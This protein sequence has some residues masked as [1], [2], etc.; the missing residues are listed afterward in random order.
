MIIISAQPNRHFC[1]SGGAQMK[2]KKM[3][4]KK[5]KRNEFIQF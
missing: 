3:Q 4:R 2:K 5:K 1:I